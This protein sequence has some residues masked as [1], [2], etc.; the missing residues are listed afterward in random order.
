M[1]AP[2]SQAAYCDL[3]RDDA[4]S[5]FGHRSLLNDELQKTDLPASQLAKPILPDRLAP[6]ELGL[7]ASSLQMQDHTRSLSPA[8]IVPRTPLKPLAAN[9]SQT[10][11]ASPAG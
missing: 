7:P 8:E 10:R 1:I 11:C 2:S 9:D 5:Q 4:S 3:T 6:A